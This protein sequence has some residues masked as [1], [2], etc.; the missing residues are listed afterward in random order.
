MAVL[1]ILL[2]VIILP[3]FLAPDPRQPA[4]DAPYI[5]YYADKLNSFVVERADGTETRLLGKGLTKTDKEFALTGPGWSPSGRWF[6]WRSLE[7]SLG[8]SILATYA[9]SVH[10]GTDKRLTVLDKL[11]GARLV[12]SPT[13]DILFVVSA[14]FEKPKPIPEES[15]ASGN[16]RLEL[17][18]IDAD[19]DQ[20]IYSET[21]SEHG[22]PRL[23]LYNPDYVE[24]DVQWINDYE[25]V[26]SYDWYPLISEE[27]ADG[28]TPYLRLIDLRT[29]T[30]RLISAEER[31][32][33]VSSKGDVLVKKSGELFL[34]NISTDTMRSIGD[35][36]LELKAVIWSLDG[37]YALLNTGKIETINV[38]TGIRKVLLEKGDVTVPY[39]DMTR[40]TSWSANSNHALLTDDT[41]F[42]HFDART[43]DLEKLPYLFP[44][45]NAY[46]TWEW[47][48]GD[49]ATLSWSEES[50]TYQNSNRVAH[51]DFS[52]KAVC[53]QGQAGLSYGYGLPDM[54][55]DARYIAYVHSDVQIYDQKAQQKYSYRPPA[56]SYMTVPGGEA[57]F[58]PTLPWLLTFKHGLI[59]GGGDCCRHYGVIRADGAYQRDL[60]FMY[61]FI[62]PLVL[63]WLPERV[64]VQEMGS[65]LITPIYPV[66]DRIIKGVDWAEDIVWNPNSDQLLINYGN[67]V[68]VADIDNKSGKRIFKDTGSRTAYW[69]GDPA[70]D[71][72]FSVLGAVSPVPLKQPFVVNQTTNSGGYLQWEILDAQTR[73]VVCTLNH[74]V[75]Q[76][77]MSVDNRLGL[78]QTPY[79]DAEIWDIR[80]CRKVFTLSSPA[81]GAAWSLDGRWL[82]ISSSWDIH[83]Y[84]TDRFR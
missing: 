27:Y 71:F 46:P 54:S 8:G 61:G 29:H 62:E 17:A 39:P 15:S 82:A 24:A 68:Y 57:R 53:I 43:D 44:K 20:I 74:D 14:S 33:P 6:A 30:S 1:R 73:Q 10:I 41:S 69:D 75:W 16:S 7:S 51:C 76:V 21:Y 9:Y 5:Y 34:Y 66:P 32:S 26:V 23:K 4:S 18:V 64:P 25:I 37:R 28:G 63:D 55:N 50:V 60:G 59:A 48:S 81:L 79:E 40:K 22:K 84:S 13:K 52:Q 38:A 72:W 78:L 36:P 35:T 67:S 42:Y 19:V 31:L 65:T 58:H 47:R 45:G 49:I 12:W 70:G 3:V 56:R 77:I 83:L 11:P 80:T 2:I